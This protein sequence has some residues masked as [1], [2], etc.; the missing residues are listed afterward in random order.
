[1][2]VEMKILK[3]GVPKNGLTLINDE[4]FKRLSAI[5]P[6]VKVR[7]R[8]GTNNQLE[9]FAKKEEKKIANR[10]VEEAFNEA[11]EWLLQD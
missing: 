1:M 5:Y 6:D 9:I 3:V 10:I 7:V 4:L 11:D 8:Y 2:R